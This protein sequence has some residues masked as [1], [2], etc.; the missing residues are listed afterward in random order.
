M[1][2]ELISLAQEASEK[3]SFQSSDES[4]QCDIV[5]GDS[6]EA[7]ARLQ[8]NSMA[9]VFRSQGRTWASGSRSTKGNI[10]AMSQESA[11]G[12]MKMGKFALP[13]RLDLK[14]KVDW[15]TV[16]QELTTTQPHNPRRINDC[17]TRPQINENSMED[18]SARSRHTWNNI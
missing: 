15:L 7:R 4:S 6:Y 8:D 9:V 2:L 5:R 13:L 10:K 16:G 17:H 3:L 1:S 12:E 18:R 14:V 11:S